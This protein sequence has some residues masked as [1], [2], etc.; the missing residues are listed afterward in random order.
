MN[1]EPPEFLKSTEEVTPEWL[2]RALRQAGFLD[3]GKVMSVGCKKTTSMIVSFCLRLQPVY[4]A[5]ATPGAPRQIFLKFSR[6]EL[7]EQFWTSHNENEV[8]FYNRVLSL[9]PDAPCIRCYGARYCPTTGASYVLLEDIADT[10]IQPRQPL[11]PSRA[12]CRRAIEALAG[13]HATWWEDSRLGTE[14]GIV[15]RGDR[16]I[17]DE[18]RD[19]V[20]PFI[21]YLGDRL[22]PHRRRTYERILASTASRWANPANPRGLTLVH[23]DAH[24]WNFFYPRDAEKDRVRLFD[25]H[26]WCVDVGP[27][28]V[29]H[30][31]ARC[32]YRDRREWLEKDLVRLY[33]TTLQAR[34]VAGYSWDDCWHDY[35]KSVIRNLIAPVRNWAQGR[36]PSLWW[37][38]LERVH[39]AYEDLGCE[40]LLEDS[41]SRSSS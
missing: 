26:R 19:R 9:M 16:L 3:R 8:I 20:M 11:P 23:G 34:G 31:I 2:T 40:E 14:F 24:C 12:N 18:L 10:H 29:A 21:N 39:Q 37:A 27:R 17:P 22:T 38:V 30:M 13:L 5:D 7:T 36:K 6:P 41:S 32:W 4:S 33:H 15:E 35:R 1:I 28:D 25:W